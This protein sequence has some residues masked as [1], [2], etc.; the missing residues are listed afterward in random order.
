MFVTDMCGAGYSFYLLFYAGMRASMAIDLSSSFEQM[1]QFS[2]WQ[3]GVSVDVLGV[4]LHG[5][6]VYA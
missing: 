2:R 1:L 5:N 3:I 4:L 6:S